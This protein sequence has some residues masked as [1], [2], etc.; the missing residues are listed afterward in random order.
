MTKVLNIQGD[1]PIMRRMT[2]ILEEDGFEVVNARETDAAA[3]HGVP[4]II[5]VNTDM[6][7][8]EKRACI[9]ALRLLVSGVRVLDLGAGAEAAEHDTGADAY[10]GKPFN[11]DELL[12]KVRALS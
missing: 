7:V 11:A 8:S 3:V 1:E 6:A 12:A 5:V 4:D 10:L 2:W 9:K